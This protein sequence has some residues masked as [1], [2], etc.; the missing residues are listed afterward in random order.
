MTLTAHH[1]IATHCGSPRVSQNDDSLYTL[2]R[3]ADVYETDGISSLLKLSQGG[4]DLTVEVAR[5]E[6]HIREDE[7][8][9]KIYVPRDVRGQDFCYYSKLPRRLLDWMMTHPT[10]QIQETVELEAVLVVTSVLNARTSTVNM[11]LEAA[12][13]IEVDIAD[14]DHREDEEHSTGDHLRS[15]TPGYV[16]Q[17]ISRPSTSTGLGETRAPRTP[18]SSVATDSFPPTVTSGIGTEVTYAHSRSRSGVSRP[19]RQ[20][21]HTVDDQRPDAIPTT[22]PSSAALN[23]GEDARYRALLNNIVTAARKAVFP[24]QGPFSMSDMLNALPDAETSNND[25]IDEYN[26]FRSATQRERDNKIG[27]AGE[28]FVSPWAMRGAGCGG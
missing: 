27:A 14:H 1:R 11:V 26:R 18:T 6:L 3:N 13:I 9:L 12:G 10:T 2:L 7:S 28:L 4:R 5:S 21:L 19:S 17:S 22:P 25:D 15:L 20:S 23:F 16:E 8:G 24:S